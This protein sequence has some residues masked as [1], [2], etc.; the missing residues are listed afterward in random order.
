[1][2]K[3]A[4]FICVLLAFVFSASAQNAKEWVKYTS[5]EGRYSAVMPGSPEVTGQ[6]SK[7]AGGH[8]LKQYLVSAVDADGGLC[9]IG[10]FDYVGATFSLDRGRDGMVKQV[11]GTLVSEENITLDGSPGRQ[12]KVHATATDGNDY[13]VRARIYDFGTRVYIVQYLSLKSIEGPAADARAKGFLDSFTVI[14]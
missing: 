10:Y 1:M 12:L 13:V 4:I 6:D 9:M 3:L 7:D 5:A 8:P 14:K 2:N 11:S